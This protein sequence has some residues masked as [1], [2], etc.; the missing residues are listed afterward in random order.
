MAQA[1]YAVRVRSNFEQTTGTFLRSTGYTVFA[2]TYQER[3]R[4]SDRIRC[5]DV[6]M[7]PGYLFCQLDVEKRLPVLQ[8]PGVLNIVGYGKGFIPISEEEIE[9][10]RVVAAS[11]LART[12]P[13]LTVGEAVRIVRGPLT[14][15][16]GI[17]VAMKNDY[18]LIVSIHLL[19]R[20]VGAEVNLDWVEP[21]RL[22]SGHATAN[23]PHINGVL[24]ASES[25][26]ILRP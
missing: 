9:A 4:G 18:R 12:W 26:C 19:Q 10:V 24:P 11:P 1:W 2:P 6:P 20:S 22:K 25:S 23:S 17:L 13:Y 7:F 15:V 21:V 3:R 8:A 16:E 5:V 14:G